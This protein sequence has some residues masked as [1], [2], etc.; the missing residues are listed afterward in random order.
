MRGQDK[1]LEGAEVVSPCV[2]VLVEVVAVRGGLAG[3]HVEGGTGKTARTHGVNQGGNVNDG[4]TAGVD[5]VGALLHLVELYLADHVLG[6]GELGDVDGDKV[7][8]LEELLKGSELLGGSKSHQGH[9]IGVN[10]AHSHRLGENRELRS[11]VT[12]SHNSERLAADLPAL[13]ANLVPGTVVHLHGAIAELTGEDNDLTDYQFSDRT[14]VA[15]WRVEDADSML[16]GVV[17]VDLV[18]AN[19][20]TT[21]SDEVLGLAKHGSR[22]HRL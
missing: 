20:E 21:N 5:E 10:D 13:G 9:D 19:A 12:V 15:E 11:N 6:L 4:S 8:N 3:V 17:Q 14:R 2:E 7:G 18:S 22:E 1:V 16:R